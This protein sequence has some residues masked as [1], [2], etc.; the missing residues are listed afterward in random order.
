MEYYRAFVCNLCTHQFEGNN[1]EELENHL[2]KVHRCRGY[3]PPY[4]SSA[5]D[6]VPCEK[7]YHY[8]PIQKKIDGRWYNLGS[9][10]MCTTQKI[11]GTCLICKGQFGSALEYV[12]CIQSHN[13]DLST[14][15]SSKFF[16]FTKNIFYA[17]FPIPQHLENFQNFS[18]IFSLHFSIDLDEIFPNPLSFLEKN[19]F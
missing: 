8:R 16:I 13:D 14:V 4:K 11:S 3:L 12:R 17:Y 5:G 18:K 15:V 1:L 19:F 10:S 7:Q 6:I 9:A 2:E